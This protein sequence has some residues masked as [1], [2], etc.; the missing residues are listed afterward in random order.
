MSTNYVTN[1]KKFVQCFVFEFSVNG[2][3]CNLDYNSLFK[4][5]EHNVQYVQ[6]RE[7]TWSSVMIAEYVESTTVLH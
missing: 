1:G 4:L 7:L 6:I 5:K 2:I 3:F